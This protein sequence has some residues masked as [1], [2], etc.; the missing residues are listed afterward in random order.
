MKNKRVVITILVGLPW[1]ILAGMV[2]KAY[3]PVMTGKKYLLP[4]KARDPRDFFRGNYVTLQYEFSAVNMEKISHDL[5]SDQEY[6]FGQTLWLD[7]H[8]EKGELSVVGLYTEASRVKEIRLKVQ[9]SWRLSGNYKTADL[10]TGLESFFAPKTV[11]EEWEKGL[12]EGRVLA[13]VAIDAGGN[14]RLTEL[15]LKP[16]PPDD[17]DR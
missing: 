17:S 7:L 1:L 9:P 8:A 5:K 13:E 14:S 12:R 10:A 16:E 6:K 3:L 11:A 4:V 15:K 2:V